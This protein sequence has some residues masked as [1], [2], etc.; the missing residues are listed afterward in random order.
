MNDLR[1]A[2]DAIASSIQ[3]LADSIPDRNQ[4][5]QAFQP[6]LN[7]AEAAELLNLGRSTLQ[8]LVQR[9]EIPAILIS[10]GPRGSKRHRC[11]PLALRQWWQSR[12]S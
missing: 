3:A 4:V 8:E 10:T 11:D 5:Q 6:L 9:G 12:Q 1:H 7:V 2:L